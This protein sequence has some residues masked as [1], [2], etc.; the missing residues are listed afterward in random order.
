MQFTV[1]GLFQPVIKAKPGQTEI[2]VL[3][4]VSDIAYMNVELTET[5]TG[6]ASAHRHHRPGRQSLSRRALSGDRRGTR[7]L[8]PPA[9]RFAI[10]VTMPATGDLVLAI[11]ERG[12]GAKT[13]SAPGVLYTNNGTD[14]P[15]AVLGTLSILPAAISYFDGFFYF[16]TQVLAR[17][18]P[19]AGR[20]GRRPSKEGQDLKAYTAFVD[21]SKV[22]PDV[23]REMVISGGFL[24]DMASKSDP[25]SFVYAFAGTAFPNVPLIQPRLGSV[26]EWSFVNNNNDEHPIHVHVNDFQTVAYDD[27]TTGLK[28]GVEMWGEDNANVPAPTLGPEESVIAPGRLSMRTRFE[29]YTGIFVLHCHRLNHE[30][31]GLMALIN[32]IRRNRPM[33]WPSGLRGHRRRSRCSMAPATGGRDGNAVPGI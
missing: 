31:N 11:P 25:K 5:A 8:I 22:E 21:V 3:A 23:R 1:N 14:T 30:D 19:V 28:T 26:E 27:P 33:R 4:N 6:T 15:P 13:V 9:S 16:P 18:T 24:N 12:G 2:W 20:A 17:A 29:E 10:A 7:L 32:V